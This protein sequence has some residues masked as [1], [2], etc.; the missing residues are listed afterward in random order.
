VQTAFETAR[1]VQGLSLMNLADTGSNANPLF[2]YHTQL[3]YTLAGANLTS[4]DLLVGLLTP[5]ITGGGLQ[6]GDSL[7]F[8]IDRQGVTIFS[9]IFTSNAALQA[10]FQDNVLDLGAENAG[11]SGGNLTLDFKFDF[12]SS[13]SG[14]GFSEGLVFG[15][16]APAPEPSSC[17]LLALGALGLLA[18]AA[19]LRRR[20]RN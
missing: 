19:Q 20:G 4:R 10:F 17:V 11:L 8:E 2:D 16:A 5:T 3:S 1:E 18:R 15:V 6:Q 7:T 13:A 9:Q 12:N 14:A